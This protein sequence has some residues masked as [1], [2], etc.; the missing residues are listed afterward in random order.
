MLEKKAKAKVSGFQHISPPTVSPQHS[1]GESHLPSQVRLPKLQLKRYSGDPKNWQEW[2]DSFE[3]VIHSNDRIS[4]VEKFT[5]LRSLLEGAAQSTI[6]G[7]QLTSANFPVAIDLLKERFT[8]KQMIINSHMD[9][10]LK[11]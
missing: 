6:A 8:K 9:S 2:W 5:H 11:L 7:L 10:L 3:A 4:E 1:F